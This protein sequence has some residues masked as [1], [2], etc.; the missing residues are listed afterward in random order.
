MRG[1]VQRAAEANVSVEGKII[2]SIDKGILLFLGIKEYDTI[3]DVDYI[4]NKTINMRI[5]PDEKG[6]LNY[7]LK[8]IGG[9]LLVVSQFTLYGDVRKGRRPN[10]MNAADSERA[11]YLYKETIKRFKKHIKKVELGQ[12]GGHMHIHLVNDGP[13]TIQL[14][15]EKLY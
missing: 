5:F 15:S 6:K 3:E 2:S 7:S 4:V 9:E 14:D 11:F 8:D 12:F 13:V 1:L 10:F